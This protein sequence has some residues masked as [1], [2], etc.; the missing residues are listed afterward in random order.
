MTWL[1]L[2]LA[3]SLAVVS[4]C[5][6]FVSEIYQRDSAPMAA[7]GIGQD[8]VDL[9]LVVPIL[10]LSFV[11]VLRRKRA[12]L[13]IFGGT[14]FYVLYSF[15][16]YSLG[17]H[18]NNLFLLYCLVLGLSLYL[19]ILFLHETNGM[20]VED[21]YGPKAPLRSTAVFLMIVAVMFYGMWLKDLVPALL[22]NSVP[23]GVTDNDLLVNP[24]H[25]I[26]I[27]FVLPGLMVTAALLMRRRRLGFV[28]APVALVFIIILGAAL[29]GMVVMLKI[30][31]ISE[32]LSVAAIFVLLAV[33]S[34]GLLASLLKNLKA[35]PSDNR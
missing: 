35:G 11:F 25:V 6:A 10:L 23:A 1:T 4:A 31:G 19:F 32:D 33:V 15:V 5:G 20:A 18:F 8:L 26:D 12:A 2:L 7:Q 9:F 21:W 17:V 3:M 30:R 16:I 13:P 29:T 22:K 28:L 27:A 34:A 24:V 14:I